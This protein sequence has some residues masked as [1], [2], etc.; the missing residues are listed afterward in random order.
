MSVSTSAQNRR[1]P[2]E[3]IY[4]SNFKFG[5]FTKICPRIPILINWN[6]NSTLRKDMGAFMIMYHLGGHNQPVAR[7][8]S[9]SP[10]SAHPCLIHGPYFV[11][12]LL[13]VTSRRAC[14]WSD[15]WATLTY[16]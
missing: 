1:T 11:S 6:K 7:T 9:K 15:D 5:I 14:K 13:F 3:C 12:R 2:A 4:L 8:C 10:P 16:D